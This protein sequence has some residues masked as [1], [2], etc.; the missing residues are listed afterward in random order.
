MFSGILVVKYGSESVTTAKGVSSRKLNEYARQLSKLSKQ[1][2]VVS[3]GAVS[4]GR[5][6]SH[7]FAQQKL[8]DHLLA[9][10]GS[11]PLVASWQAAFK[12]QRR[13]AGQ[14]LVTHKEIADPVEGASLQITLKGNLAA[15]IVTILNENDA[16]SD[17]E[18]AKL[19][20]G[21]DNDGL[22]SHV[23]TVLK[24][25]TL[26]LMTNVD[27]LLDRDGGLVREVACTESAHSHA[28]SCA[29]EI[30]E[31]G[32]GMPTKIQAAIK[33]AQ[34]GVDVY[35][36]NASENIERVLSG[37]IGTHFMAA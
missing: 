25:K 20:Y 13:L 21:G 18:L 35:I 5:G 31:R 30:N 7:D 27:G 1:L 33:A 22:A 14:L 37:E 24:A 15:G 28:L 36:G 12:S 32:Q 9:T 19:V 8:D 11:A 3:S 10:I 26:V 6:L 17:K 34:A 23:A 29:G 2:V 16:L 4:A